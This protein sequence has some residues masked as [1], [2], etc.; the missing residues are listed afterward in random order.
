MRRR[1][2]IAVAAEIFR[3]GLPVS[4]EQPTVRTAD[5]GSACAA[6]E[7]NIEIPGHIAQIL[8]QLWRVR[9]ECR[10]DEAFVAVDLCDWN[11]SPFFP[12]ETFECVDHRNERKLAISAIKIGR[13]SCRERVK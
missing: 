6:I 12:I 10:E 13:A 2:V 4:I 1:N 3:R 5:F 7:K 9:V 11:Q 8:G